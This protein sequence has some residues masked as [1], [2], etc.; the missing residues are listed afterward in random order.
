MET[1]F[2]TLSQYCCAPVLSPNK[3]PDLKSGDS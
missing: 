2:A 1:E 3:Q